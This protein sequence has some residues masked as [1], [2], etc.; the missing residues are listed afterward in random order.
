[1]E[2]HVGQEEPERDPRQREDGEAREGRGE[3]DGG[4]MKAAQ[5]AGETPSRSALARVEQRHGR[6][7]AGREVPTRLHRLSLP[8]RL[9][10]D[11]E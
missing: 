5:A 8:D 4:R 7:A 1:V 3:E 2:Q 9:V 11:R 10:N 6:P